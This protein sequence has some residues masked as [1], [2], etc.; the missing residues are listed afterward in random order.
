MDSNSY[1]V[2]FLLIEENISKLRKLFKLQLEI[3]SILFSIMKGLYMVGVS[4]GILEK[5]S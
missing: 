5:E 2:F 4:L 1:Q 3:N